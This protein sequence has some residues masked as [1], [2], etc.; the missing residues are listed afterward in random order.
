MIEKNI[1]K[2]TTESIHNN[3]VNRKSLIKVG[4]LKGEVQTVNYAWLDEGKAFESHRHPD[5]TE[6]FLFIEGEG[7]MTI[8]E[9][10]I[11]VIK[12][13]FVIVEKNESH[14]VKNIGE[15]KLVFIT[16]RVLDK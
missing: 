1:S 12:D 10:T 13:G 9:N 11:N 2:I 14:S 16:L 8:N 5:G 4:E 15:Q 3:S 6:C 7:E